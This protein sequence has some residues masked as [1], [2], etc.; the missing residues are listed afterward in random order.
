MCICQPDTE[1]RDILASK[2]TS[3]PHGEPRI[4]ANS[5]HSLFRASTFTA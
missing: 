3:K 5:R 4:V 2:N 1:L